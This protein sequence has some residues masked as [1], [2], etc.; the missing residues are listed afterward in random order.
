[1][2][3]APLN[4]IIGRNIKSFRTTLGL[5]QRELADYLSLSTTMVTYYE[6]G[7]RDISMVNLNKLADLFNVEISYLVEENEGVINLNAA[8][9][10]KKDKLTSK[11]INAIAGFRKI[12]R[13]YIKLNE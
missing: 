1:M 13:N 10:F 7:Q 5:S 2:Q 3:K 11:D 9:A 6:T 4:T 8:V 12:V